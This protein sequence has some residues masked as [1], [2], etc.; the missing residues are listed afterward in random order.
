MTKE[1]WEYRAMRKEVA[2]A[3][4]AFS[5]MNYEIFKEI[6]AERFLSYMPEDYQGMEVRISPVKKVNRILDGLN[7]SG[8]DIHEGISMSPTV[9]IQDIY[10]NYLDTGDLQAA[11][12][13]AAR[14]MDKAFQKMM[15][16]PQID[17]GKIKDNVIFE[18]INTAQ[19]E[20]LLKTMPHR[21]F[22]DL[23]LIYRGVL[24]IGDNGISS[25]M[26]S[27][28][29]AGTLGMAEEDLY[30]AA[31]RNTWQMLP[32]MVKSMNE[33]IREVLLKDGMA[34]Q[35]AD[36]LTGEMSQEPAMWVIS[37]EHRVG[38]AVSML[39]E[40][41]LHELAE[42]VGNDLYI[43]PSSVHEVIAVS[44]DVSDPV[45]LAQMVAEINMGQVELGERL[46]NQVY[47]YDK[48]LRKLML[49]TDTP[50]KRLDGGVTEQQT[51]YEARQTR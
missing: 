22:E 16:F 36:I 8:T 21:E 3:N 37:N 40:N 33:I 41:M 26:I 1:L 23:S 11:L 17:L 13:N 24:E 34:P 20:E 27:N 46:S 45:T 12:R 42:K 30:K 10:K 9:Y 5:I 47:Y 28:E 19:N 44:A 32:P 50:N 43:M 31:E 7:F 39:Y 2:P 35:M 4:G 48:D 6:V 15:Q 49:A 14:S 25:V 51:V 38:G 29:L 18:L